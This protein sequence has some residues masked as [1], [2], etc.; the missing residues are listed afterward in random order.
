[1]FWK[2]L[3]LMLLLIWLSSKVTSQGDSI[4]WEIYTSLYR[5]K[6]IRN[7]FANKTSSEKDWCVLCMIIGW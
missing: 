3:L 6:A 1:V 5:E 7:G 2:C 4:Y